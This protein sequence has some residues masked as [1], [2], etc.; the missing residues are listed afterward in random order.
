MGTRLTHVAFDIETS[1]FAATD[2]VTVA[3][4]SLPLG[5]RL[6]LNTAGA[7][8]QTQDLSQNLAETF[9]RQVQLSSHVDERELLQ[10]LD[11]FIGD[12]VTDS[13]YLL[14]AYNGERF[15]G[16]FDLPF[17]RTRYACQELQWPFDG[18][19]YADLLPLI[20]KRFNTVTGG[21][22][23]ND[24]VGAYDTLIDGDL[25]THDPFNDSSAAASAFDAGEFKPLLTHNLA[26]IL[27]TQK[28]A[29]L[30]QQYCGTS[31]FSVKSL[32]PSI[33]DPSLEPTR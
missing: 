9:D 6:F 30:A 26:D 29:G 3:G 13:E 12:S 7:T 21:D 25:S 2:I 18:L 16:G 20:E 11:E 8:V 27:R 4:L 28:L 32:T 31:E 14:I 19:P 15:T 33:R 24:L 5:S 17:L 22:E 23:Q 1:G 10:A